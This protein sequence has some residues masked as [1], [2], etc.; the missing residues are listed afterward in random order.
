[1]PAPTTTTSCR[2]PSYSLTLPVGRANPGVEPQRSHNTHVTCTVLALHLHGQ[3]VRTWIENIASSS[4][5]LQ[6]VHDIQTDAC[7]TLMY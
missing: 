7:E 3:F 6:T 5:L 4:E 2:P 1:M